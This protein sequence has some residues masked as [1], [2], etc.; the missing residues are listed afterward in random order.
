M[1]VQNERDVIARLKEEAQDR[2]LIVITHRTSLLDLVD[3]VIVIEDG[4]SG[5]MATSRSCP[6]RATGRREARMAR[7]HDLDRLAR[8]MRGRSALRGSILLFTIVAF[9]IIAVIWAASTEIDDVTRA[10]GRIVPSASVQVIEAAEQGV[11][12]SLHVKEGQIVEKGRSADGTRR[13]PARQ[14]ARPGTAARL[15]PDGPDRAVAGRNRRG[16][17]DLQP[18]SRYP[19]G[20]CGPLR[21]RALS[22]PAGRIA[23]GNRHPRTPAPAT[24]AGIRGRAG[25][26]PDRAGNPRRCWK[27]NAI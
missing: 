12:Q 3:R 19:R 9:L 13:H 26:P 4:A 11:L 18:R 1:D 22:R 6:R 24:S 10:D 25:R 17:P 7:D 23:G 8:E 27:R 21:D 14:P 16:R 2:T 5:P 15:W 20:G